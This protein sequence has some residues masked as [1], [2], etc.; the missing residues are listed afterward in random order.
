MLYYQY[1]EQTWKQKIKEDV[2]P[3]IQKCNSIE[4]L[5][6]E[7]SILGY[8]IKRGK[9]IAVKIIGMQRFARLSTIDERFSEQNLYEIIWNK[10]FYK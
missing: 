3:L 1:K 4:E 2:E 9:N 8:E 5:L 6:E 7:L 10:S